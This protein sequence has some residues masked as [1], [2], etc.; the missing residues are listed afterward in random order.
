MRV[1]THIGVARKPLG[2][3]DRPYV[4]KEDERPDH[5]PLCRRQHATDLEAADAA[6][7]LIDHHL[8]HRFTSFR[9]DPPL[10]VPPR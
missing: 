4:I 7:P 10:M 1:R 6:P 5:V 8:D 2:Q 3:I 9:L